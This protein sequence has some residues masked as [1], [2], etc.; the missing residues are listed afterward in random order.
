[1]VFCFH[2]RRRRCCC[3]CRCR[4]CCRYDEDKDLTGEERVNKLFKDAEARKAK[5]AEK[6]A[7][8]DEEFERKA[9]LKLVTSKS[10]AGKAAR[11]AADHDSKPFHERMFS[12]A[13]K[14]LE[15]KKEKEAKVGCGRGV[16]GSGVVGLGA[17]LDTGTVRAVWAGAVGGSL[18][19]GS[20][21]AGPGQDVVHAQVL[22]VQ[23]DPRVDWHPRRRGHVQGGQGEGGGVS[24]CSLCSPLSFPG[25]LG[26]FKTL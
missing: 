9:T 19:G 23:E 24:I 11:E 8:L 26:S 25:F 13:G 21:G 17:R 1:M 10:R 16:E 20:G 2:S 5:A 12:N 3:C 15:K 14:M 6:A 22:L 4:C 7:E 18:L